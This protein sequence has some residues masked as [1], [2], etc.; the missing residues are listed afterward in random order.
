MTTRMLRSMETH[1]LSMVAL[2]PDVKHL[3]QLTN[4]NG[5]PDYELHVTLTFLGPA[6]DWSDEIRMEMCNVL[7]EI[8]QRQ[9]APSGTPWAVADINPGGEH[10][11]VAYLV[12]G[13]ELENIQRLIR[14]R[15]AGRFEN[16]PKQHAPWVPH[17]TVGYGLTPEEVSKR[18]IGKPITFSAIRCAFGD[19]V[20]DFPFAQDE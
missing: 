2:I 11:C 15:L 3:P 1:T 12:E 19:L 6:I 4:P 5:E 10:A 16:I 13:G 8:T 17:I 7:Q 20:V 14:T 9:S 18:P